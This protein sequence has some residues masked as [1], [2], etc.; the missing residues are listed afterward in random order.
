M[1]Y[2]DVI[3]NEANINTTL[4]LTSD[5]QNYTVIYKEENYSEN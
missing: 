4:D 3:G 5:K 1:G 2:S